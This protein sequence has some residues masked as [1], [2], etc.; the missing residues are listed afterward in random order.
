MYL[1]AKETMQGAWCGAWSARR[2]A[3]KGITFGI[4]A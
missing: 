1:K 3:R 4:K 2:Q